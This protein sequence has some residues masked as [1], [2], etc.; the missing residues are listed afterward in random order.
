MPVHHQEDYT[1]EMIA[2][3]M[4]EQDAVDRIGIDA[5]GLEGRERGG[6]AIEQQVTPQ[7]LDAEAGIEAAAGTE[8]V[9]RADNGDFHA[10]ALG[11]A[12]TCACQR[13]RLANSSGTSSFAGFM[14]STATS[15]VMSATL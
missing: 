12:V 10:L 6:A 1:A 15:P 3:Q 5:L 14:K 9:A 8:R 4:A 11:R 2:V 13:R 7:R